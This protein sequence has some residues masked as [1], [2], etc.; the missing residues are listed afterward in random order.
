MIETANAKGQAANQSAGIPSADQ[1][2]E[3]T[4]LFL[5][6]DNSA[7]HWPLVH[8]GQSLIVAAI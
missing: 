4:H 3:S 6:S 2:A 1:I 7:Q 5:A 8:R